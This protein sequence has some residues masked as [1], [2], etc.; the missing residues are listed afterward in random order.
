V[1][2]FI[3]TNSSV[4]VSK[5]RTRISGQTSR[6]QGPVHKISL[7]FP[8]SFFWLARGEANR[9][10]K[11]LNKKE[12]ILKEKKY[13]K[14]VKYYLRTQTGVLQFTLRVSLGKK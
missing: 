8:T 6:L 12:V 9:I 14:N 5:I 1:F 13:L 4:D 11:S 2:L 10:S 7:L 3:L